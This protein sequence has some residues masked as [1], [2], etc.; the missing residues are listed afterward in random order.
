MK[1]K[2]KCSIK[3]CQ[4]EHESF[5]YCKRHLYHFKKYGDPNFIMKRTHSEETKRK[6]SEAHKGHIC[7]KK[8]KLKM[9]KSSKGK[10]KGKTHSK[11]TK[12][13]IS[14]SNKGKHHWSEEMKRKLSEN[15]SGERNINW[16]GGITPEHKRIRKSIEY[17]LWREAVFARDNWTCQECEKRG[18]MLHPHHIKAFSK[19]PDFRFA[20]DNGITLCKKCHWGNSSFLKHS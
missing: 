17:R 19:Y 8:T 20:I 12:Q 10:N 16:K 14:K 7:S 15:N 4:R 3:G 13:K 5:G 18:G 2:R 9:S 6:I 1:E 11:E